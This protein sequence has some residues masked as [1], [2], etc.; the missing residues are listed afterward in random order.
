MGLNYI[1]KTRLPNTKSWSAAFQR[2][3]R[4]IFSADC[5]IVDRTYL[6][7]LRDAT[8]LKSGDFVN[9]RLIEEKVLIFKDIRIAAEIEKPSLDLLEN[10]NCANG[11]LPG[12]VEEVNELAGVASV[13]V[14]R[15]GAE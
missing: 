1:Y 6:A 14:G 7:P 10:L 5:L 8:V 3:S 2:A 9:V 12:E 4:D 15:H 11:I 13:H